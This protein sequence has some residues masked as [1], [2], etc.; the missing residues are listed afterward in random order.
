MRLVTCTLAAVLLSGCSWLGGGHGS[1]YG[2]GSGAYGVNC[3]PG[4]AYGQAAYGH[5]GAGCVGGGYGVAGNGYGAGGMGLGGMGYGA[6]DGGFG[7]GYGAGGMYGA[8]GGAGAYGPGGVGYGSGI[9]AGYGAGGAGGFGTGGMGYGAGYGAG[10]GAGYGAGGAG[11]YGAGGM[12]YGAGGI[13]AGLAANGVGGQYAGLGGVGYGGA[14]GGSGVTTLGPGATYGSAY[15]QNVVG[16]QLAN[17]Q[18]VN[19]AAVQTVQGAPIYV[20]Q[21]YPAYY[22][23]AQQ[24]RGSYSYGFGGG[25]AMPFGFELDGGT[26]FD[27]GGDIFTAK[28]PGLA[29]GSTTVNTGGSDGISYDDAFGQMKSIGGTMGYDVSRNTTVLGTV[30][31]ASA[32]GKTAERYQSVDARSPGTLEDI[33]ATFSDLDLWTIE[34]GVR[35]YMGAN[36]AM[37]PYVGATAG[38]THNNS[39][40]IQRHY[41]SDGTAYDPDPLEYVE[42]GWNPTAA[43]V[44]GAEMAV[45]PRAA[46]GVESGLRWRDNMNTLSKSEDRWSV[47]LKLR[48]R[49]AF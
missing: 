32:K 1:S 29:L 13:G 9:G 28:D 42:S 38:F 35:Q 22:G 30:N 18:W 34:G 31:Y 23:V 37:R 26:E 10:M 41:S 12:G 6:G 24:L 3:V 47:P 15:G 25:G 27:L 49:V 21:P 40:D 7:A 16:T 4:G 2:G 5:G 39:V 14:Y 45:G 11:S 43:A 19:G 48:G 36:P 20:P 33:D 46:I 8:G 17:G 44:V